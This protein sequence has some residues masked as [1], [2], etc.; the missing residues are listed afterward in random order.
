M[1][2][3]F[4]LLIGLGIAIVEAIIGT[5]GILASSFRWRC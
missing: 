4:N 3:L 5:G 1:F 2:F